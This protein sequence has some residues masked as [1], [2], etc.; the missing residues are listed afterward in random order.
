LYPDRPLQACLHKGW[1]VYK[2]TQGARWRSVSFFPVVARAPPARR[3]GNAGGQIPPAKQAL[4][5]HP[6]AA[7]PARLN[8][9]LNFIYPSFAPRH[10][11]CKHS[12]ALG[13]S[14][15]KKLFHIYKHH[16]SRKVQQMIN[17]F[18]PTA[19]DLIPQLIQE[20]QHPKRKFG[21]IRHIPIICK[22]K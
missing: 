13:L 17:F 14:S 10:N 3:V 12:S 5:P 9:S 11:S 18:F 22:N 6:E 20:T 4:Q 16:F 15:G 1:T 21:A 8:L 7:G 19:I 2:K